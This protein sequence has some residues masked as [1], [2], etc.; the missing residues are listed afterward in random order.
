MTTRIPA[1]L[2][3]LLCEVLANRC[4]SIQGSLQ[5]DGL[6][7]LDPEQAFE[8]RQALTDELCGTGLEGD[9]PNHRGHDI[10]GLIDLVGRAGHEN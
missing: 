1:G 6:L 9:E 10:E 7:V 2:I 3:P 5:S 4:P 8:L